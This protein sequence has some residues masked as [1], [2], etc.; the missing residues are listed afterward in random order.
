MIVSIF[1]NPTQFAPNED[2]ASYPRTWDADVAALSAMGVD[3][4]WA[5]TVD[6]M[7]PDG[8]ATQVTPGGP[9]KAGL[10]DAFRPHFFGGVC[11][12]V[13]KLL[14]QVGPDFAMFGE[15]DFQQ[16]AVVTAMAR[17]LD[18]PVKIVGVPTV[19]EKDG[20]AMSSRNAYLSPVERASAPAL[21]RVLTICA[22]RL[23]RG[24]AIPQVIADG[25]REIEAA[26]FMV[27]YLELRDAVTLAP[28]ANASSRPLRVLVAAKIGRTRLID[29]IAV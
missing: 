7:Y 16:L 9:A 14:L 13:A 22:A 1:V 4:I 24:D 29:N 11:T 25:R 8:F 18:I 5:P 3:I 10:E 21:H 28:V 19:R 2:L 26:G 15:K 20:L 23:K 6:T 12:V 17:D 27:D